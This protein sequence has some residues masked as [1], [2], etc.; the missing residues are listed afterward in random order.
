VGSIATPET[1]PCRGFSA[2][3]WGFAS[4]CWRIQVALQSL[5]VLHDASGRRR[6]RERARFY[7][8]NPGTPGYITAE[9]AVRDLGGSD[10][11]RRWAADWWKGP[12]PDRRI[13]SH[14][15][16]LIRPAYRTALEA[17]ERRD[18]DVMQA[19][20]V[21]RIRSEVRSE[22]TGIAELGCREAASALATGDDER[23]YAVVTDHGHDD[24]CGGRYLPD[25]TPRRLSVVS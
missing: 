19:T 9:D 25:A 4:S 6:G 21:A 24:R 15:E 7:V 23:I 13:I 5:T 22:A 11:A 16:A 8:F 2:S 1:V 12:Y 17:W 14:A 10:E 3:C 18:D 20:E